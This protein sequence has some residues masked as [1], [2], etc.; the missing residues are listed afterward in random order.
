M[1][2]FFPLL[3]PAQV[4][5]DVAMEL[6]TVFAKFTKARRSCQEEQTCLKLRILNSITNSIWFS[7]T[8]N[9]HAKR[10]MRTQLQ[11]GRDSTF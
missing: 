2:L 8:T 10:E 11:F 1:I 3:C 7:Q 4:R 6:R 9:A 5:K